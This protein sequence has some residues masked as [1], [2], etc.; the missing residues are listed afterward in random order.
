M[1]TVLSKLALH[2]K[3]A[4]A[5]P[6]PGPP[7][8]A[9]AAELARAAAAATKPDA[10]LPAPGAEL[11]E[12]DAM[13]ALPAT[14]AVLTEPDAMRVLPAPDAVLPAPGAEVPADPS[15]GAAEG[16]AGL[17]EAES[18]EET[19][20]EAVIEPD[21]KTKEE[22]VVLLRFLVEGV[23]PESTSSTGSGES[24]E[25]AKP[26][27]RQKGGL[28]LGLKKALAQEAA[29]RQSSLHIVVS[30]KTK[31]LHKKM[32]GQDGGAQEKVQQFAKVALFIVAFVMVLNCFLNVSFALP[33]A[34]YSL[35]S[36]TA[37]IM[38][39]VA[40]FT[41]TLDKYFPGFDG[42][43]TAQDKTAGAS[44]A[45]FGADGAAPNGDVFAAMA[46]HGTHSDVYYPGYS[47]TTPAQDAAVRGDTRF[48]GH[49]GGI[50]HDAIFAISEIDCGNKKVVNVR[51]SDALRGGRADGGDDDLSSE[52]NKTCNDYDYDIQSMCIDEHGAN[53]DNIDKDAEVLPGAAGGRVGGD[54]S[55]Q[56]CKPNISL[57]F[58]GTDMNQD[59]NAP[60]RSVLSDSDATGASEAIEPDMYDLDCS[61]EGNMYKMEMTNNRYFKDYP[62]MCDNEPEHGADKDYEMAMDA[63]VFTDAASSRERGGG[64]DSGLIYK[65]NKN[66]VSAC[67]DSEHGADDY[68]EMNM[69]VSIVISK[70]Y[71]IFDNLIAGVPATAANGFGGSDGYWY[72]Y[73]LDYSVEGTVNKMETDN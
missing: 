49:A 10:V 72:Q 29:P 57:D 26:G 20:E 69:G 1:G 61:V 47:C 54:N 73:D 68:D 59:V 44:D 45:R 66:Y 42:I 36:S 28:E 38:G 15:K 18:A 21:A 64:G 23:W 2:P 41:T 16:C 35:S 7:Q 14:D 62:R 32:Q 53:D 48:V 8:A 71:E 9:A 5:T 34:N 51:T 63:K 50:E 55:G 27:S 56:N 31:R 24:R 11:A 46:G 43:S 60:T 37:T 39:D 4:P 70:D 3:D 52:D 67:I 25:S 19:S 40:K 17:P 6:G 33:A 13:R 22:A 12:P 58:D 30:K 65:N